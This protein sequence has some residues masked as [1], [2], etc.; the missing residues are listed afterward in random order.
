MVELLLAI[1]LRLLF[2]KLGLCIPAYRWSW[3]SLLEQEVRAFSCISQIF[4]FIVILLS[5]TFRVPLDYV[6]VQI[7]FTE[8]KV[9]PRIGWDGVV[10]QILDS[11]TD[12]EQVHHILEVREPEVFV[13]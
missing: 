9:P 12:A 13:C 3:S 7:V 1:Q 5:L 10:G 2:M 4:S 8:I 6:C 11:A